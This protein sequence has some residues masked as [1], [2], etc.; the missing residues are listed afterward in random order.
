VQTAFSTWLV[1]SARSALTYWCSSRVL[2]CARGVVEPWRFVV[3]MRYRSRKGLSGHV[4]ALRKKVVTLKGVISSRR[5]GA[6]P[7]GAA[8]A[9]GLGPGAPQGGARRVKWAQDLIR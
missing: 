6:S 4:K 7:E 8:V 3:K 1:M 2:R 9:M 5:G